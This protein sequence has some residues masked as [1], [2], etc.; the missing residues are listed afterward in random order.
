NERVYTNDPSRSSNTTLFN[1]SST[2]KPFIAVNF[3][4]KVIWNTTGGE[5][6][7]SY[8]NTTM[9][10]PTLYLVDMTA[11]QSATGT[12]SP[13]VG[14]ENVTITLNMTNVGAN[15]TE[16][17]FVQFLGYVPSNTTAGEFRNASGNTWSWLVHDDVKLYINGSQ[18]N[19]DTSGYCEIQVTLPTISSEGL[20]N[21]TIYDLAECDLTAGGT[22]GHTFDSLPGQ[23]QLVVEYKVESNNAM[24]TG[25]EYTFYGTGQMN[26]SSDTR[27]WENFTTTDV[28]VS[29]KRII[30]WKQ[31]IAEDVNMPTMINTT[32]NLSVQDTEGTGIAGIK[33][34]D[35]VPTAI[36][37]SE[38]VGNFSAGDWS[39]IRN[40]TVLVY[41]VDYDITDNQT[42]TLP[43]GLTVNA[44]EFVNA[45]G[46][47][48]WN[49]T[50]GEYILVS[51]QINFTTPG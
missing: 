24:T 42:V 7:R 28:T 18:I 50:D 39:V 4:W 47:S 48:T 27:N 11:I 22:V 31:L 6:N 25:D 38:F 5:T 21:V 37:Y 16:P 23:D 44:F 14:G 26:S 40:G 32:I 29:G 46:N 34:M 45:T 33:F 19:N 41:G 36:S 3:D 49:L 1:T 43:D 13:E 12:V 10:L 30:G 20:V 17:H 51:Y 35:Y 8:I 15:E 9:D 2:S